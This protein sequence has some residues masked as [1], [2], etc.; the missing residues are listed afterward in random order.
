MGACCGPGAS[1]GLVSDAEPEHGHGL[2]Q[3]RRVTVRRWP[4][5][6]VGSVV[7]MVTGL[8]GPSR[9]RGGYRTAGPDRADHRTPTMVPWRQTVRQPSPTGYHE[10]RSGSDAGTGMR[11]TPVRSPA[12]DLQPA[13]GGPNDSAL[14]GSA[15]PCN[16][17]A[18]GSKCL[19][20]NP[21]LG[22]IG[23]C[24]IAPPDPETVR[25]NPPPDQCRRRNRVRGGRPTRATEV[26][27]FGRRCA[28]AARPTTAR[29]RVPDSRRDIHSTAETPA[30]KIGIG[31]DVLDQSTNLRNSEA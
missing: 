1:C 24:L 6:G 23:F 14:Q 19:G 20:Q 18:D 28:L 21:D 2:R 7:G 4:L 8:S 3:R 29:Y 9:G 16:S 25:R 15:S 17:A 30:A 10:R 13:P 26:S 22:A 31:R 12:W 27:S 5:S 11:A